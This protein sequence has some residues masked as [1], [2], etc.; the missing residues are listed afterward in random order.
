MQCSRYATMSNKRSSNR[1]M[2][3]S[4]RNLLKLGIIEVITIMSLFGDADSY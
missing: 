3:C 2:R 4:Q 1:K